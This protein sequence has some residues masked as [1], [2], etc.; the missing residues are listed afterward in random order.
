M[1]SII[2]P[3]HNE[4]RLLGATLNALQA[5]AR[6][7][8]LATEIV[9]VDDA[10]T[11]RTAAV[12][13]AAGARVVAIDRRQIAAARN[14]GAAASE[15]E[16]LLFVDADT[17]VD[18]DVV[19]GAVAALRAGAVAGGASVAFDG[20]VPRWASRGLPVLLRLFRCARVAAGCFLFCRRAAFDAVGGFDEKLYA[21]EEV[22]FS[23][24]MVRQGDVVFLPQ[25]VV[26][27]GR[28]LRRFS[29][30]QIAR[31]FFGQALR[32]PWSYRSRR[33]LE[34][35]YAEGANLDEPAR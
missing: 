3:A 2:V 34:F 12:A 17:L 23:R 6:G 35:W 32:G 7:L 20:I 1:L 19:Q 22:A 15:G 9:V 10:S 11:D 5:A 18:A 26:T 24:A 28:K 4:E 29:G 8:D 14:A 33:G 30:W 27:S 16:L 25:T 31:M 13:V 21:S